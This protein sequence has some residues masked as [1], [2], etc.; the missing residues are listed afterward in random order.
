MTITAQLAARRLELGWTYADLAKRAGTSENAVHTVLNGRR[1]PKAELV[2]RLAYVMGCDWVLRP[3]R[4][5]TSAGE[6][7]ADVQQPQSHRR[8]H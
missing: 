1:E 8:K 2:Q 7:V 3:A 5:D 6:S 4:R